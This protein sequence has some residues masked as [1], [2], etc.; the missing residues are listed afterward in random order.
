ML[1]GTNDTELGLYTPSGCLVATD[2]DDGSGL[3]TQLSFGQTAPTRAIGTSVG[4][5]G[6][7]GTLLPAGPYFLAVAGFNATFGAGF[8]VTTTSAAT[9]TVL[10]NFRLGLLPPPPPPPLNDDC[11]N[12]RTAFVGSHT[13]TNV[14]ATGQASDPALSCGLAGARTVWFEWL[15]P[16]S[17]STTIDTW[18]RE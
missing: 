15:A 1:S 7:D 17:G 5:N 6:R 3:L 8:A 2:D 13:F 16:W 9:G 4:G 14:S 10:V 18:R 12:P 11:A